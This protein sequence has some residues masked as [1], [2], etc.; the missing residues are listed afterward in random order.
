VINVPVY[1]LRQIP[2]TSIAFVTNR[3]MKVDVH[4]IVDRHMIA[5][6]NEV[7]SNLAA[8]SLEWAS[9]GTI[10]EVEWLKMRS[11]D[12]Q[13]TLRSRDRLVQRLSTVAC[14]MCADF[15]DHVSFFCG[16]VVFR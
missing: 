1:E 3:T 11:L 2:L 12:F 9:T 7:I 13:E 10:P 6:M 5:S 15:E 4:S 16:L 14:T 8:L